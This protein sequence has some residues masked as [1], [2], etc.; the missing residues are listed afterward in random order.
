MTGK[1]RLRYWVGMALCIAAALTSAVSMR[2]AIPRNDFY[3]YYR[4]AQRFLSHVAVYQNEVDLPYKYPPVTILYWL[5]LP[6]FSVPVARTIFVT[7]HFIALLLIPYLIALVAGRD[8]RKRRSPGFSE[9]VLA[10]TMLG[11]MASLRF[12]ENE[13]RSGQIGAVIYCLIYLGVYLLTTS[14]LSR[15]WRIGLGVGVLTLGAILKVHALII[16]FLFLKRQPWRN[17]LIALGVVALLVC[18]PE[19]GLWAD[20]IRQIKETTPYAAIIKGQYVAQGIYPFAVYYFGAKSDSLWPMLGILPFLGIAVFALPRFRLDELEQ[21]PMAFLTSVSALLLL[22]VMASPLPWV[23]TYSVMLG[24]V[25]TAYLNSEGK[26]R[27]LLLAAVAF[28]ALSPSGII[29]TTV[30]RYLES[31]QS[32][33]VVCGIVWIILVKQSRRL[34]VYSAL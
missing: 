20:W 32:L 31:R 29:G 15:Y 13:F 1:V 26:E 17:T 2:L 9:Q 22:G 34:A 18:L 6:L 27:W 21:N 14:H 16:F 25:L 10:G 4:A 7:L 30:A 24:I 8:I 33:F 19:P 28:L 12:L 23:H 3:C 11:F 5:W